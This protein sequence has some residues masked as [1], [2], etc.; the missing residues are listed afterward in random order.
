MLQIFFTWKRLKEHSK[1]TWALEW[2]SN[3]TC[4]LEEQIKRT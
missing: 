3:D 1:D 2:N 4:A